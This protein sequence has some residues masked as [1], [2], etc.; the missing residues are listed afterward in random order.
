MNDDRSSRASRSHMTWIN[1]RT[2]QAYRPYNNESNWAELWL[3]VTEQKESK[4]LSRPKAADQAFFQTS[5]LPLG[6]QNQPV[7]S[8]MMLE[9]PLSGITFKWLRGEVRF[10][11]IHK[12]GADNR[13][14]NDWKLITSHF[15][16]AQRDA[17]ACSCLIKNKKLM[18][19]VS[20]FVW[21]LKS[22]SLFIIT[23]LGKISN[24]EPYRFKRTQRLKKASKAT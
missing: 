17:F 3:W 9:V 13:A 15:Y 12:P 10:L 19:A 24:L 18:S 1:Q 6:T 11:F 7:V 23:L 8:L 14:I 21:G 4:T 2:K 20:H 16:R 5:V 22:R